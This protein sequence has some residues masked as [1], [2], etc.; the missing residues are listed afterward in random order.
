MHFCIFP[1]AEQELLLHI[2]TVKEDMKKEFKELIIT[3]DFIFSMGLM[4]MDKGS[5]KQSTV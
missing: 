2:Y 4:W 1:F 5:G 3:D